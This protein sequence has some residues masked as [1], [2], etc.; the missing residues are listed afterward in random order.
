MRPLTKSRAMSELFLAGIFWGFG[1]IGTVWCLKFLSPSAILF[2]RFFIAFAA[3]AIILRLSGRNLKDFILDARIAFWPGVFL[4]LTLFFQTWGLES[5]TAT[6]STFITVLYVVL[7]PLINSLRG[8][9]EIGPI[10][11]LC[12]LIALFGTGFIV[13]LKNFSN[14]NLGDF[15]TLIC[16]IFAA[17]HIL[18]VG[19]QTL[20]SNSSLSFNALQSFWISIFSLLSLPFSPHWNLNA[21]D[22]QAWLGLI[23]LAFGSSLLAFFLQVR[24]QKIISPSVVSLMFLLESPM[25]SIFAFFLL[26]EILTGWQWLGAALI[27]LS[28]LL[29]SLAEIR[30][31][32]FNFIARINQQ[33]KK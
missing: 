14:L 13:N 33:F 2:Y 15:L 16:A 30:W 10:H 19:E 12:V 6:N 5:T 26:N 25:S 9:E 1:F 32:P 20:K 31:K 8:R 7:V 21:L 3:S 4:W 29:I 23:A 18:I 11:W 22:R 17:I 28:C 24:A 27:M